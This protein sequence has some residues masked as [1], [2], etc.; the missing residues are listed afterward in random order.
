[1]DILATAASSLS[2]SSSSLISDSASSSMVTIKPITADVNTQETAISITTPTA[3]AVP[4]TTTTK[5]QSEGV[6]LRKEILKPW[7]DHY[8]I[9]KENCPGYLAEDYVVQT[10][11]INDPF[12]VIEKST[13]FMCCALRK[14]F[15]FATPPCNKKPSTEIINGIKAYGDIIKQTIN[16]LMKGTPQSTYLRDLCNGWTIQQQIQ[17]PTQS[18]KKRKSPPKEETESEAEDNEL[19]DMLQK[20][21]HNKKKIKMWTAQVEE[22]EQELKDLRQKIADNQDIVAD[23]VDTMSSSLLK[24]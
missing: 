18:E 3:A 7:Y 23:L 17:A 2:S 22:M 20:V 24:Q 14:M 4:R 6:R 21:L 13:M 8:L 10:V 11:T 5:S 9:L 1:M 16:T 15:A 19:T 12:M